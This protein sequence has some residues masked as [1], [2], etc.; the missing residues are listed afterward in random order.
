MRNNS[1]QVQTL[2]LPQTFSALLAE[3]VRGYFK[4]F[5]KN[6]FKA[7]LAASIAVFLPE[8]LEWAENNELFNPR[9]LAMLQQFVIAPDNLLQGCLLSSLVILTSFS[10]IDKVWFAGIFKIIWRFI[11]GGFNWLNIVRN[12][13]TTS[14]AWGII[15]GFSLSTWLEN[16]MI[17][18]TLF[19]S[20]FLAGIVPECSGLIYFARFFWNRFFQISTLSSGIKPADE[21]FRGISPGLMLGVFFKTTDSSN[22]MYFVL[23]SVVALL[24][25]IG[26]FRQKRS[27]S[28]VARS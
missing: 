9:I 21:F 1:I 14:F 24:M 23:A 19:V 20:T 15:A 16:P 12:T 26:R 18:L 3:I 28:N 22:E 10:F 11:A 2:Q 4:N 27:I 7:L 17:I 25:F 6:T 5:F 8:V 13:A